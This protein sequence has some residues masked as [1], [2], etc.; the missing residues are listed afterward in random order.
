MLGFSPL[1]LFLLVVLGVLAMIAVFSWMYRQNTWS[2]VGG[3]VLVSIAILSFSA[4]IEMLW[5]WSPLDWTW[6]QIA[7]WGG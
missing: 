1:E 6:D 2:F 7:G 5:G 3:I 4:L